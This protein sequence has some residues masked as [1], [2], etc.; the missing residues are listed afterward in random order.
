MHPTIGIMQP[1]FFPYIGYFQLVYAVDLFVFYNDVHFIT[2]G[3]INRNKILVNGEP[4]YITVPCQGA[5]QNKLI[6]EVEHALDDRTRRKMLKTVR[7]SYAN[8]PHFDSV[9]PFVES[10]MLSDFQT[11]DDLA[12]ESI[13]QCMDYLNIYTETKISSEH[14]DNRNLEKADRLINICKSEGG[15]RYINA[16]GGRQLYDKA[17]FRQQD[18]EL[19]FLQPEKITYQQFGGDF[20]PG[21]SII[22]VLMFNDPETVKNDFLNRYTL[23]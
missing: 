6:H 14:Y 11:I 2:G 20:Q 9:Y 17:Y 8:A 22:D 15:S 7:F 1:Y 23:L 10:V 19:R 4:R 5:S 18:I 13:N 3:W 21:L 16:I 12:I